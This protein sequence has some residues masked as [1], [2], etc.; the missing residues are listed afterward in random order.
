MKNGKAISSAA[1]AGHQALNVLGES[2]AGEAAPNERREMLS[3]RSAFP[4][5]ELQGSANALQRRAHGRELPKAPWPQQ[6]ALVAR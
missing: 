5:F 6:R 3:Y 2:T 1:D 4:R